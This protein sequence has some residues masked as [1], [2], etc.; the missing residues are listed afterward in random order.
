VVP[1]SALGPEAARTQAP[2]P[3]TR[4]FRHGMPSGAARPSLAPGA[5]VGD[6]YRIVRKLGEGGMGQVYE[7]EHV[8]LPRRVA[9]KV[10]RPDRADAES[11]ARF[12]QEARA[13]ARIGHPGIVAV[14]DSDAL[15]DGSLFLAMEL[16]AGRSLED[17]L[18]GPGRLYDGVAWLAAVARALH[19]AHE[20]GI[21]HRDVKPANVFLQETPQGIVPKVLD[22]G[23]AKVTA[24]D[25]TQIATAA[26]TLLGTPYYLAPE[27]A[28][29]RPPGPRAD[30]Y[31]LGVI[32]Y[33][34]LTGSVP[35]VDD[36][37]MGV[38]AQHIRTPPLDPRQAAPERDLPPATC[39]LAMRL[40]DKDPSRRPPDAAHVA[41]DLDALLSAEGAAL[42]TVTT[43][44]RHLATSGLP[45]VQLSDVAD[46]PTTAPG[47][48][49][50]LATSGASTVALPRPSR[51]SASRGST[52]AWAWLVAGGLGAVALGG[53]L[54]WVVAL[55]EEAQPS[56]DAPEIGAPA[57]SAASPA[58]GGAAAPIADPAAGA[59]P[60]V[61]TDTPA[62]D[63]P[64]A[65]TPAAD[66]P[67]ADT[68]AA[69]R[70]AADREA[71]RDLGTP[72][73][74][75][76]PAPE[77]AV[78]PRADGDTTDRAAPRRRAS[79]K[80]PT[81]SAP[82]APAAPALKDDVYDD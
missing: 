4:P 64:A 21:V 12:R 3:K 17:W 44:P 45:T 25:A 67:A 52:G 28:L 26:G 68:P 72:A 37:F 59:R 23:I 62:A 65:D 24:A 75:V 80:K 14:V 53:S 11:F 31:S 1:S 73:A 60:A 7:A 8:T 18:C 42:S 33:E 32:L 69:A 76:P 56:P 55:R 38:L 71:S 36:T 74:S 79:G 20:A 61:E 81:T 82:S 2:G 48:A 54:V 40:L 13:T 41:R 70:D 39:A 78:K 77:H 46:R 51:G 22:F 47:G 43:G 35:F 27:R 66:T 49:T 10:L 30:L 63:T 6:R 5:V 9:L 58:P 34:M 19:A 15:G 57:S 16:L 50:V 29:G